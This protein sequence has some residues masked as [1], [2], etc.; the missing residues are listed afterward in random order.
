MEAKLTNTF[1]GVIAGES[2]RQITK[3]NGAVY[4]L[5][6][7]EITEG[8]APLIGKVVDGTYT[9]INSKGTEKE[10]LL[11]GQEIT[12]YH[13]A[14]PSIKDPAIMQH[15]FEISTSV[16]STS[17]QELNDIFSALAQPAQPVAARASQV[18]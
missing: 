13:S 6:K 11:M 5:H 16:P 14:V 10:P 8:P 18:K 17:Q 2:T 15:F 7:V 9:I 3:S 1:K 4:V 12:V